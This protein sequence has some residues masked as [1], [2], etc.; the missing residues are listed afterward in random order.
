M[1]KPSVARWGLPAIILL[2]LALG[3][4]YAVKTPTWQ[5]PD[6]PAHFNYI[7]Y[8]A[9]RGALPVLRQG[10]YNQGYLEELKSSKFPPDKSVD[11]I[12]YESHQPPLYYLAATPIYLAA[13][14]LPVAEQ[15]IVLRIFSLLLGSVLL[16]LAYAIVR[17]IFP[18]NVPLQLAVPAFIALVPQHIAMTAAVNNDTFAEVVLAAML[19]AVVRLVVGRDGGFSLRAALLFGV[20]VGAVLLTKTTIYAAILL[21]PVALL[22]RTWQDKRGGELLRAALPF[23]AVILAIAVVV[24]SWWFIRNMIVYGAGDPTGLQRHDVVVIGQPRAGAF[25]S[26]AAK[27][28]FFT[29]FK[30]FWAQLGWM[31]VPANNR[32]YV[33]LAALTIAACAGLFL[34]AARRIARPASLS[35]AQRASLVILLLTFA[36]VFLEM[37]VYNLTFIQPQGRYLFP[38]LIPIGTFFVLGLQELAVVRRSEPVLVIAFLILAYVNR[39]VLTEM[40]P[41]LS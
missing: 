36:F 17:Q 38:A 11:S 3:I 24:A 15:V 40:I 34:F 27:H 14:S 32:T 28:F 41:Y 31:G 9:T 21:I 23:L 39:Y 19:L 26:T 22:L 29:S 25:D 2:H 37:F 12:R 13:R 10:D 1:N 6:E 30:S 33:L 20:L 5:T 16:A 4:A 8:I 35:V 18:R 7:K